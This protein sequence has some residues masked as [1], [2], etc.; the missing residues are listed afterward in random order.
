MIYHSSI[1]SYTKVISLFFCANK[2]DKK[3]I[4]QENQEKMQ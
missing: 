3:T 4:N 2:E 1:K